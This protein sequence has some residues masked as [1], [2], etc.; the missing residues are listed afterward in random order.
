M[1][2]APIPDYVPRTPL[3]RSDKWTGAALVTGALG[4]GIL[5]GIAASAVSLCG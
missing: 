1:A 4:L 5:I 3:P 2:V